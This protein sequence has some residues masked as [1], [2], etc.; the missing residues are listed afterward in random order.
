[1]AE[2]R[3]YT[4][5]D[6][7]SGEEHLIRPS[8]RGPALM[9]AAVARFDVRATTAN[10]MEKLYVPGMKIPDA[11]VELQPPPKKSSEPKQLPL[12]EPKATPNDPPHT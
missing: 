12:D 10:D 2:S 5:I 9:C 8:R 4:L 3:L 1:M 11:A 7:K 6:K